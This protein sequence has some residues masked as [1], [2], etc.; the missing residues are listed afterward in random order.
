MAGLPVVTPT[1]VMVGSSGATAVSANTAREERARTLSLDSETRRSDVRARGLGASH[2]D[3][4]LST[5]ATAP[6]RK[7]E[8]IAD[9]DRTRWRKAYR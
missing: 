9:S 4:P 8:S 1:V 6:R 2:T 7:D 5:V 3:F